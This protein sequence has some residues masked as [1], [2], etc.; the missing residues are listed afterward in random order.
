MP[1]FKV[2]DA[3]IASALNRIIHNTQFKKKGRSG[4][5][6]SPKRGPFPPWKTDRLPDLRVLPGHWSQ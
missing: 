4:G 1:N 2:F 5:T 3:K 6:K